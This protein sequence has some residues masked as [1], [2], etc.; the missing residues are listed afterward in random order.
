M[1]PAACKIYDSSGLRALSSSVKATL[2]M[3]NVDDIIA[4]KINQLREVLSLSLVGNL[5]GEAG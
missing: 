3:T 4:A 1:I 5:A 2:L